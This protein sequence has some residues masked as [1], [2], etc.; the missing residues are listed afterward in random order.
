[1]KSIDVAHVLVIP[2]SHSVGE[3]HDVQHTVWVLVLDYRTV[4]KQVQVYVNLLMPT[5]TPLLSHLG[6]CVLFLFLYFGHY[7]FSLLRFGNIGG[8]HFFFH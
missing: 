5:P 7:T 6:L 1:M 2:S 4:H 8:K 3:H